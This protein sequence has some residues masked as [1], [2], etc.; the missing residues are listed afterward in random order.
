MTRARCGSVESP[1]RECG[2]REGGQMN[3]QNRDFQG[4]VVFI[5]GETLKGSGGYPLGI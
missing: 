5:T 4:K 1:V 3:S 2:L